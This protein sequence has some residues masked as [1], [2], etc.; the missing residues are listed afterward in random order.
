M[1]F[2]TN[3]PKYEKH[4]S[5]YIVDKNSGYFTELIAPKTEVI[6]VI[7]R[8]VYYNHTIIENRCYRR[9]RRFMVF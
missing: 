9:T 3:N 2:K 1:T 8:V 6:K 7:G 5:T 4:S